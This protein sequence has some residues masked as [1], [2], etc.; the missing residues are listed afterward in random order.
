MNGIILINKEAGVSSNKVVNKVKYLLQAN[1]AG[2]L[3][4]LDV[5][6]E[7]L[8]PVTINK[9]TKVF[10]YFLQKDKEYKAIFKFGQTT[11]TLDLEGKITN[12]DDKIVTRDMLEKV[13]PQFVG[14]QNQMPPIYSAKKVGGKTAYHLA[15]AGV[16]VALSPKEIEIY[17]IACLEQ[18]NENTFLLNIHCSSGTYIRSL[19]RDIATALG[20][21]GVMQHIQRTKCGMFSLKDAYTIEDIR[22][23]DY[24]VIGLDDLFV[25]YE[26]VCLTDDETERIL[27]GLAIK[28]WQNGEYRVYGEGK[29]LGIGKVQNNE[30]KLRLRLC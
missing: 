30:L 3:G 14:K 2:H 6:G 12:Q 11:D 4:T 22:N 25:E 21:Y 20:T 24:C 29:F 27:N 9:G 10:E 19:V 15:R 16:E 1:K 8:L 17:D 13:L 7:G 23:G 18:V 5:L 26:K 28:N